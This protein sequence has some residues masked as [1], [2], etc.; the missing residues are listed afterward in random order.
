[1][2]PLVQKFIEFYNVQPELREDGSVQFNVC[3]PCHNDSNPSLGICFVSDKKNPFF[4]CFAGCTTSVIYKY[5]RNLG[6]L[7]SDDSS[8]LQKIIEKGV[9]LTKESV[10]MKYLIKRGIKELSGKNYSSL[11]SV[12]L[13]HRES[14][15]NKEVLLCLA[16]DQND[17]VT[18]FQRIFLEMDGN[19]VQAN[20]KK[21]I[22]DIKGS[23]VV[24]GNIT[25]YQRIHITEG[26][27]T[28]LAIHQVTNERV[29]SVLSAVNLS[30]LKIGEGIKE[31]HIWADNDQ[32]KTG[33]R[34][35]VK[36]F[37]L[38]KNLYP[39]LSIFIH[40]P[41]RI[42]KGKGTDWLDV[43]NIPNGVDFIMDEFKNLSIST[44]EKVEQLLIDIPILPK[45]GKIKTPQFPLETLPIVLK[46]F[47][48]DK[49]NRLGVP[50]EMVATPLLAIASSLIGSKVYI[51]P[52]RY[53]S[54]YKIYSNLW[55]QIIGNP[56]TKKTP[57][58]KASVAYLEQFQSEKILEYK[59]SMHS[60]NAEI[61]GMEK[62]KQVTLGSIKKQGMS[63]STKTE[64]SRI[65]EKLTDLRDKKKIPRVLINDATPEKIIE[66]SQ[67]SVYGF[68]IYR[69]ELS[70]LF[71]EFDKAGREGFRQLLLEG[72]MGN[73]SFS[74]DRKVSESS[75]AKLCFSIVGS[76][77]PDLFNKYLR[78]SRES[79]DGLIQRFQLM[80]FVQESDVK[81]GADNLPV[82][83]YKSDLR[84]FL[85]ELFDSKEGSFGIQMDGEDSFGISF[86]EEAYEILKCFQIK[87][88]GYSQRE[89]DLLFKGHMD[90]YDKLVCSL[91]LIIHLAKKDG[92]GEIGVESLNSAIELAEFY[93]EHASILYTKL[94]KHISNDGLLLLRKIK[95]GEVINGMSRRSIIKSGWAG[96]DN[97]GFDSAVEELSLLNWLKIERVS[98]H[99]GRPSNILCFSPLL[100]KYIHLVN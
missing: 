89:E 60:I 94:P 70:G 5:H 99:T 38:Y 29:L 24:L 65:E 77:Q 15:T 92:T 13:F 81:I 30:Q 64:L 54:E 28:G 42:D 97:K 49:S 53:D 71:A 18:G 50:V 41:P 26:V 17:K 55:C 19:K 74:M 52:K 47:V 2:N 4:K 7:N 62:L 61:E 46:N 3:C 23:A 87:I 96:L 40:L 27:E 86:S 21:M 72:W 75:S 82:A 93:L 6:L 68:M 73:G 98:N 44:E 95:S 35:T 9:P 59:K 14:K 85:K 79:N 63:E 10:Q 43:L 39:D 67:H 25:D 80:I 31:L 33:Q 48:E 88:R 90:K 22:G 84:L 16:T 11:K 91:S 51:R 8:Y 66:L 34:E 1:M 76:T 100:D 83:E 58:I 57:A 36:A 37:K 32:S 56:S 45:N 12:E 78:Q 69:D 20:A